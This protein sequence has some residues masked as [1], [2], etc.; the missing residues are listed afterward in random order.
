M[1]TVLDK[2]LL[3]LKQVIQRK[4]HQEFSVE[5]ATFFKKLLQLS[6]CMLYWTLMLLDVDLDSVVHCRLNFLTEHQLCY[7]HV[8]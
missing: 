3:K 8:F 5:S 6:K 4:G 7:G 1:A 2:P